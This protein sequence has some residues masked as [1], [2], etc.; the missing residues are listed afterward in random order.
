[1][2][3]I[4]IICVLLT[5]SVSFC[6][7]EAE[8]RKDLGPVIGIDLG[9]T[10]SCVGVFKNCHVEII[11]N[12]Q[13]NRITPSCVAFTRDGVR[14]IG[15]AAKNILTSNP[16]STIFH[17]KRIIGR[18]FND[19]SVQ[20]DIKTFP[21]SVIKEN[22][23][24]VVKVD[25]GYVIKLFTPEEISVMILGKMRDIAGLNVIRIINEPTAAAIAYGLN[26]TK[27]WEG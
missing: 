3:T 4:M 22:N 6:I 12:D 5:I 27:K 25:I 17:I 24:P 13:G 8:S 11:E 18:T 26:K 19:S 14:L 9:T 2:N 1:M 7:N 21:F 10:Y 20:E 16:E 15:D 23:K